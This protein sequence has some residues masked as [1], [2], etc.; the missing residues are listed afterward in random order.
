MDAPF[1]ADGFVRILSRLGDPN[2]SWAYTH[3]GSLTKDMKYVLLDDEG[4]ESALNIKTTTHVID[5]SQLRSPRYIG[6]YTSSEKA[7][8][9]NQYVVGQYSFQAN[10][11]AGLRILRID[12]AG[13]PSTGLVEEAYYDIKPG[14]DSAETRGAWSVYPYFSSGTILLSSMEE[15]LFVF[16]ANLQ[17]PPCP[18]S[19]EGCGSNALYTN[20]FL[21]GEKSYFRIKT[22]AQPSLPHGGT[23]GFVG[24]MLIP[25]KRKRRVASED[26]DVSVTGIRTIRLNAR[27]G[28]MTPSSKR[29][30]KFTISVTFDNQ[31]VVTTPRKMLG[32]PAH[33]S[34]QNY[35]YYVD[36]PP[37]AH[38]IVQVKY[39]IAKPA[40]MGYG[41]VL[42][43]DNLSISRDVRGSVGAIAASRSA[44]TIDNEDSGHNIFL[45]ANPKTPLFNE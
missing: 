20:D 4:D 30:Y 33:E 27:V 31:Q 16:R 13:N 34:Y 18:R 17:S 11:N 32:A 26:V 42:L 37:G 10:Y 2:N 21:N 9:H 43:I 29:R 38:G 45:N 14:R 3:Q 44:G 1:N 19:S 40:E 23:G 24:R 15:G 36:V 8:D 5:V 12:D 22:I 7:T 25:G 28:L 35:R 41:N 6:T 39:R